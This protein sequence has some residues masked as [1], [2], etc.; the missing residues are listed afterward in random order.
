MKCVIDSRLWMRSTEFLKSFTG[1]EKG[2]VAVGYRRSGV[3]YLVSLYLPRQIQ[4]T[5]VY[6]EFEGRDTVAVQS[7]IHEVSSAISGSPRMGIMAWAHT[8]PNLTVFLSGTDKNTFREWCALDKAALAVVFDVFQREPG[9]QVGVFDC[10]H[11]RIAVAI[12]EV[13]FSAAE[14]QVVRQFHAR[15]IQTITDWGTQFECLITP[16]MT[17]IGDAVGA[18]ERLQSRSGQRS[19]KPAGAR[20]ADQCPPS[21]PDLGA[22]EVPPVPAA[23][24]TRAHGKTPVATSSVQAFVKE[25]FRCSPESQPYSGL[26]VL[27]RQSVN[28]AMVSG[29]TFA[30][31]FG[32]SVPPRKPGCTI[33]AGGMI[34]GDFML[35][36]VPSGH[37]DMT[38]RHV[39]APQMDGPL[40]KRADGTVRG[41]ASGLRSALLPWNDGS[42]LRLLRLKGCGN[43]LDGF[44]ERSLELTGPG[45]PHRRL[46]EIRGCQFEATA[47]RELAMTRHIN[48]LVERAGFRGANEPLWAWCYEPI[49]GIVPWCG[50]FATAG[51]LRLGGDVLPSLETC[52]PQLF[53]LPKR[54]SVLRSETFAA[55][56]HVALVSNAADRKGMEDCRGQALTLRR[57]LASKL[58]IEDDCTEIDLAGLYWELGFQAGA[59]L[60]A[61]HRGGVL[62]GTYY[63]RRDGVQHWNSHADNFVCLL[64]GGRVALA[65]LDFDLAMMRDGYRAPEAFES[66]AKEERWS[67]AL[68]LAGHPR[69]AKPAGSEFVVLG[70]PWDRVRTALRHTMLAA[71]A[72]GYQAH[73]WTWNGDPSWARLVELALT[74][75]RRV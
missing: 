68:C 61:L 7:A 63:D 65:P 9:A 5:P 54:E 25:T 35:P 2:G 39:D 36:D 29:G 31:D 57:G 28:L 26:E 23:R 52:L 38:L 4:S 1:A 58:R 62:W 49:H 69:L 40:L 8:H 59:I 6:C 53:E 19:A 10:N 46:S 24:D 30:P 12:E 20:Q 66:V 60:G 50:V 3:T 43:G 16:W 14:E 15:A 47:A 34:V 44:T 27:H 18:V 51:D 56:A 22:D 13:A 74:M 73:E 41:L 32:S 37:P 71:L 72:Q 55:E 45:G 11:E 17:T 42:S 75:N 21:A 64:A 67:L 33:A 48:S 70:A